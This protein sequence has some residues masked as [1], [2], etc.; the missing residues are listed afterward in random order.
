[1]TEPVLEDR[2]PGA[3]RLAGFVVLLA[4]VSWGLGAFSA[5]PWTASPPGAALL[6]LTVQHVAAL[7]EG[8]GSLSPEELAKLPRHMRPQSAERAR[9]GRRRDTRLRVTLDGR[10]LLDRVYR[11][12]GL[13]H[14]GPTFAY[15]ELALP[16]GRHR[17]EV[18]LADEDGEGGE[19]TG[20]RRRW[21]LE[22][23][24]DIR[25]GQTPLV[26]FS[27]DA[28]LTLRQGA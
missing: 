25:P 14:D 28:G 17:L 13:R 2:R 11:P 24:V 6:R 26:E 16:T 21:R 7:E 18:T 15:E 20:P 3:R 4:A 23:D 19:G 10:R 8:G 12:G 27:E 1:V 5:F 9:T 22:R